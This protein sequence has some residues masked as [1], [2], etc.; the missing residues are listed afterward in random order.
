M[1]A[2]LSF[3]FRQRFKLLSTHVYFA[4]FFA[5][6]MLWM[7]AAG[8]LMSG[9]DISFG[10]K[11]WINAPYAVAQTITVLGYLGMVVAAAVMGRAV[12]HD[13][14][15]RIQDFFF[16]APLKKYQYFFGR[17]FAA[18]LLVLYIFASVGLA[19]LLSTFLPGLNP[20][21]VGPHS[22][23]LYLLPY[24]YGI[25]PNMLVFGSI[26]FV[27]AA[28]TRRM[29]PVYIGSVVL[30]IGYMVARVLAREYDNRQLA[31]LLD[32]LG[33]K[34]MGTITEYW[35]VFEKNH[36]LIP[37]QG[38][39]LY[40][41]LLWLT[42][43]LVV[44]GL[45]YWRFRMVSKFETSNVRKPKESAAPAA[46]QVPLTKLDFS[47]Q[48]RRQL[49]LNLTWINVRETFKNIYFGVI[50]FA[51][52]LFMGVTSTGIGK[53]YGTA[54]YPVTYQVLEVLSA[55][56]ALFTIIITTVYAGE[57]V[58]R[59]REA[60]VAQLQDAL[61]IPTWLLF[62]PKL[63]T[64]FVL[65]LFMLTIVL[66]FGIGVQIW[67]G[68]Y[69]FELDVYL[70]TLYGHE[71]INYALIAVMALCIQILVNQ[72]YLAY[73]ITILFYAASIT[74]P[75]LGM[76]HPMLIYGHMPNFTYSDMNGFGNALLPNLWYGLYW[77][78]MA[79]LMVILSLLF[80]PR[81]TNSGF[82]LRAKL[83]RRS[84]SP[85]VLRGIAVGTMLFT[86]TGGLL[87]YNTN[88]ANRY[89]NRFADAEEHASYERRYK[90]FENR[91][92]PRITDVQV[93]LD[94]YPEQRKALIHGHYH[95]QNR[96]NRPIYEIFV[97]IPQDTE[98]ETLGF[99]S[100]A[101][102]QVAD[103]KLNF[104]TFKLDEPLEPNQK[105][106]LDFKL[107]MRP[108]GVLGLGSDTGVIGNG[109]F[110]NSHIMPQIGYQPRRELQGERERKEHDL[111]ARER[112]LA[113]D[114]AR[115]LAN[116]Y[117]SS[118]ADW[119]SFD[120]IVSTSP[121]QIAL[122]PGYLEKEWQQEGRRYFHYKMDKPILNFYSFQ[123]ANYQVKKDSWQGIP[124]EIYYQ[125][126]HE[127]NLQRMID[128]AQRSLSYYSKNFSPYQH[129]QL[130]IVEFPRYA[131]FA[132]AFPN[133]IPF[134]ESIGFIAKVKD[135]DPKDIDY[136]FYVTAHE[137]AHQWWA[138]QLIAGNTRGAT[139]LSETL[140]QYSALMVMK[141][142]Y[143]TDKMR[144]FLRHEL[145]RY[146][147]DRTTENSKELALAH[148]EDQGYI[149][150]NKGSLIMYWLADVIGEDKVNQ[151][152]RDL[153]QKHALQGPPYPSARA[154]LEA[155]RQ[156]T[157]ADMQYLI[158]DGF[159]H[160]TLYENRALSASAKASAD[161]QYEVTLQTSSKKLRADELGEEKAVALRDWVDIG[162]DDKDG[163][164]LL[165]QRI[166]LSQEKNQ[167]VLKVKSKPYKAGIDP[168]NKLIDRKPDDNLIKVE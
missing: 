54:T 115:G 101:R 149:H 92:Q 105:I 27:L 155:L 95:L 157:P 84:L 1:W 25:L 160:I 117:I 57:L 139:V 60:G 44:L 164:P 48:T 72:K 6:T 130:R 26:F 18:Y 78:G 17:F 75:L 50:V 55:G 128:S 145:D 166:L 116:N 113:R 90:R 47:R 127:Y 142:R 86:L 122:A 99:A 37:L 11:V 137:V 135:K 150:Y 80:W 64:L 138:H 34:A 74:L 40:N 100:R 94:L 103:T 96:S 151:A 8:G 7:A 136:P 68:Y 49:L 73:F 161:G 29:L 111:P 10:D 89:Q 39:F 114:D 123:S 144:R 31:A 124:L 42:F 108:R 82:P 131:S 143:G 91:P 12:Q 71:F 121:E 147:L 67:H 63:L 97:N 5:I 87:F 24:L 13:F 134:S 66:V 168:D 120:A 36:E 41:R 79:I 16:T 162:L 43:A 32:P 22:L 21:R 81:G 33:S 51:G 118:D 146:L 70:L 158:D 58:W 77:G 154:L 98:I 76:E 152:L 104:F 14:E 125:A 59:E 61:P 46:L 53:I 65:Q 85:N 20:Q 165:R 140:S 45:G 153:L 9:T 30:L 15:Y 62:I 159:E 28:L 56:F 141:E 38:M 119:I 2:I 106:R 107:A 126:G 167:Y 112:K 102:Q 69:R 132:Q 93:K 19:I 35:T 156:V 88:I 109:T 52:L 110:L 3:E 163:K 133:T 4:M 23:A 129:R 83:A 148:N